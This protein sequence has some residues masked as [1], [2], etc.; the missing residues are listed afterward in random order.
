M[1]FKQ[2]ISTRILIR[3]RNSVIC[4]DVFNRC[5]GFYQNRNILDIESKANC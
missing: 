5:R 4:D 1:T 2:R 3:N